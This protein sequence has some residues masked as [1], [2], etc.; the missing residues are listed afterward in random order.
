MIKP[1]Y[2]LIQQYRDKP[3]ICARLNMFADQLKEIDDDCKIELLSIDDSFGVQLDNIGVIVDA[4]RNGLS[5]A[6]YKLL[7]KAQIIINHSCGEPESIIK[8]ITTYTKCE[9]VIYTEPAPAYIHVTICN[10]ETVPIDLIGTIKRCKLGG[11]KIDVDIGDIEDNLFR[12]DEGKGF[13]EYDGSY[14]G[15]TFAEVLNE[16][17]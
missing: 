4:L 16:Q 17:A 3:R 13:S 6:D 11:V 10:P 5:D 1:T 15:G 8:L 9:L 7:L 2:L 12:F 14:I